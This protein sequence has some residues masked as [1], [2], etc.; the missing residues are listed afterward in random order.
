MAAGPRGVLAE[1]GRMADARCKARTLLESSCVSGT[2]GQVVGRVMLSRGCPRGR[3]VA[4]PPRAGGEDV[5]SVKSRS[6]ALLE[7]SCTSG[8]ID[9]VVRAAMRKGAPRPE[10]MLSVEL[11]TTIDIDSEEPSF[12]TFGGRQNSPWGDAPPSRRL[13]DMLAEPCCGEDILKTSVLDDS[14]E[15]GRPPCAGDAR[16][17]PREQP[18]QPRPRPG[19]GVLD[20]CDLSMFALMTKASDE[21]TDIVGDL[22][23]AAVHGAAA[24]SEPHPARDRLEAADAP[25]SEELSALCSEPLYEGSAGSD[26]TDFA[27]DV[28]EDM[29]GR[30]FAATEQ[31]AWQHAEAAEG[32]P[33]SSPEQ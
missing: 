4:A 14:H 29:A 10:E 16:C 18:G 3:A 27:D 24:A 23:P 12:D 19:A 13:F 26:V 33:T 20:N 8:S 1:D 15:S 30:L 7:A 5:F 2:F 9:D 6:R 21:S 31:S 22:R 32:T 28:A 11:E 17:C 25:P